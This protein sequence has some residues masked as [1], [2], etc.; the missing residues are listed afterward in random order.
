MTD[1]IF[2]IVFTFTSVIGFGSRVCRPA[3]ARTA[4]S[5][6]VIAAN[7]GALNYY[8]WRFYVGLDRDKIRIYLAISIS[9]V[10]AILRVSK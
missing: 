4:T 7:L 2:V 8:P 3:G 1:L 6:Y 5:D 10:P 9:Y